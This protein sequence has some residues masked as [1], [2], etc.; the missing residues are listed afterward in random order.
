MEGDRYKGIDGG[1]ETTMA[2][3]LEYLQKEIIA[4]WNQKRN[5]S[6][7]KLTDIPVMIDS[8]DKLRRSNY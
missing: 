5:A 6:N 4:D 3:D 8:L 7:K 2:R 1:E